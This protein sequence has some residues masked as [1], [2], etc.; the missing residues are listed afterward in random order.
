MGGAAL[1]VEGSDIVVIDRL[2]RLVEPV[3]GECKVKQTISI[4]PCAMFF[5]SGLDLLL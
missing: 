1:G 2:V 3:K 4:R 5:F